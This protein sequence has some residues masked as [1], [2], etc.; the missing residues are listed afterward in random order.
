MA[1]DT[2]LH[3]RPHLRLLIIG[4]LYLQNVSKSRQKIA[5]LGNPFITDGT[6]RKKVVLIT[7]DCI[8]ADH[9]DPFDIQGCVSAS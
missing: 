2:V 6:V 3:S 8:V 7:R 9:P 5:K 1:I 4:D